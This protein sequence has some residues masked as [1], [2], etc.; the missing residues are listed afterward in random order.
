M[1]CR[2]G[3]WRHDVAHIFG[4]YEIFGEE[5][6]RENTRGNA[7]GI[8]QCLEDRELLFC[9]GLERILSTGVT[10][11]G[12]MEKLKETDVAFITAYLTGEDPE[13][14]GF[15][16]YREGEVDE[17]GN[18]RHGVEF[19]NRRLNNLRNKGLGQVLRDMGYSWV[20]GKGVYKN[21]TEKTF[22][23]FNVVE[24]A[25]RFLD[26]MKG[27]ADIFSQD[28]VLLCPKGG[29]WCLYYPRDRRSKPATKSEV[30]EFVA[31]VIPE[32]Y[33]Q[34]AGRK[35]GVPFDWGNDT[36]IDSSIVGVHKGR[37]SWP[38]AVQVPM[39]RSYVREVYREAT[40]DD[41]DRVWEEWRR[42]QRGVE[43]LSGMMDRI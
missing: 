3:V 31:G 4:K 25:D 36:F 13:S 38:A 17:E 28:S 30:Q 10:F 15:R 27:L 6:F 35:F 5:L 24:R 20:T 26:D 1:F 19:R 7:A 32:A 41:L 34:Y 37:R 12:L 14:G 18:V 16:G 33:T 43:H 11:N 40:L 9:S 42:F 8:V 39:A 22:I 23:V 2:I 21:K 29:Q